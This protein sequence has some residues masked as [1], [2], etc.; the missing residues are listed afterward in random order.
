MWSEL[1]SGL[2]S[3]VFYYATPTNWGHLDTPGGPN[4]RQQWSHNG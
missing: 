2:N 1:Y 3:D 4:R